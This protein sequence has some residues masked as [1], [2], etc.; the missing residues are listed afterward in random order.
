[1]GSEVE[2]QLLEVFF[3]KPGTSQKGAP[4]KK[5][6]ATVDGSEIWRSPVEIYETL[7]KNGEILPFLAANS[8]FCM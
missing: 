1:M 3:P 5:A 2:L 4:A 8:T 6:I 7:A